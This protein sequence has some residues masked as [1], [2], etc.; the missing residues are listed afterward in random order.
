[1]VCFILVFSSSVLPL[2]ANLISF[3]GH[4]IYSAVIY[5]IR[6]PKRLEENQKD[7]TK[8]WEHSDASKSINVMTT[9]NMYVHIWLKWFIA[10][11]H[12]STGNII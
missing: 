12:R 4:T 2:F 6:H 8:V 7:D 1:M 5:S 3:R 10:Y 9:M 11:N